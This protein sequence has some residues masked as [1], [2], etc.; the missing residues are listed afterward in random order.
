MGKKLLFIILIA[1]LL[2]AAC[3]KK[4]ESPAPTP[5]PATS[6]TAEEPPAPAESADATT[7]Q[8]VVNDVEQPLYESLVEP[9]EEAN[10]DIRVKLVSMNEVLGLDLVGGSFPDDGWQRLASQA[11][12]IN[13]RPGSET[14]GQGLIRDLTPLIQADSNFE[15]DDFYPGTLELSQWDGGVWA[16][17]TRV[18]FDM[19]YYDKDAF[20]QA[21]VPY[22]E[23]GWNWDDFLA[24][25]QALTIR[26]GGDVSRWGFVHPWSNHLPFVEGRAGPLI[27][28][29]TDPPTPRLDQPEVADAMRWYVDLYVKEQVV[30]YF[31]EDDEVLASEG[32]ALV[33][34]GEAPMWHDWSVLFAYRKEQGNRGIV[35]YPVDAPDSGTTMIWT[36]GLC[37]SAGTAHPDAAWRWMDFL[38]RQDVGRQGPLVRFLPSR[39]SVAES[40]GYWDEAD[41][42]LVEALRYALDHSYLMRQTTGYEAVFDALEPAL[43]GE[44][45]V[46]NALSEAQTEAE[47]AIQ[48]AQANQTQAT[49]APTVVVAAPEEE[50]PVGEGA[51][52]IVFNPGVGVL[53]MQAY[54]DAAQQFH[55]AHPD[56]QVEVQMP[57]VTDTSLSMQSVAEGSDCFQWIPDIQN[58]ENQAAILSLKPFLDADPSFTT[59]DFYP[60]VLEKFD[61]QGQ[62]WGLPLELQPYVIEYNKALFDAAN[63]DYPA[64]GVSAAAAEV[65]W[66]TDDFVELAAALT[67][68]EGDEKQYGFVPQAFEVNDLLLLIEPRGAQ[69]IDESADP[70]AFTLDDPA[71]VEALRWYAD[72]STAYE[73]KPIFLAD[74]ARVTEID[75]SVIEREALISEGRAAMWTNMGATAIG[76]D[77]EGL[78]IGVAPLPAG[79]NGAAGSGTV[80]GYFISAQTEARQACWQW[81]TFLTKQPGLTQ[82][83][84]AR[85]SVAESGAYRQQMG[86]ERAAVYQASVAGAEHP[87]VFDILTG[88]GWLSGGMYWLGRAYSQVVADEASV[89]EALDA[90]Q[91][92]SEDYH[93][94]V[95]LNDAISDEQAWQ[96]CMQEVDPTLPG[97]L[98]SQGE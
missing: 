41:E 17:P 43:S 61:W 6:E 97:F 49:P 36:Q 3:G 54:R 11:D 30:P 66:T 71:T 4:D 42:E 25:A 23:I 87:S 70:P 79:V 33:E 40:V 75:A 83:L 73:V 80:T 77:R 63:V 64:L 96:A 69:L 82:G 28:G 95:V 58:P 55:E 14:V 16:L 18:L 52:T 93:A 29:S 48:E 7:I 27:D 24:T 38:T 56:I 68:G 21:G 94:C 13:I 20:D 46:E 50:K 84:P 62:L 26:E 15:R 88:Q 81:I 47:A 57:D 5:I 53:N 92:M 90:A 76:G 72:M 86:D 22:P 78:D 98:F 45:S 31:D 85:R 19:I 39:R 37:M 2:L 51:V 44:S 10:P 65:F 91:K 67:Q 89:E 9:F 60:A 74:I 59:D 34:S 12:V 35:P 8:F 32:Q 1:T